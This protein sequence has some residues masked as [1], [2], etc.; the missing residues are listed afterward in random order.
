MGHFAAEC[1]KPKKDRVHRGEVNLTQTNDDEPALL[2]AMTESDADDVIML[3][4]GKIQLERRMQRICGISI[5][6]LP[7][8]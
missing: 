3:S 4:E 6:E 1:R 5:M 8:I 2:M 7:T